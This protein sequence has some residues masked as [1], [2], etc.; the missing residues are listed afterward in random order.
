MALQIVPAVRKPAFVKM[1]LAGVQYSGK[2]YTAL[3]LAQSLAGDKPVIALDFECHDGVNPSTTFY[4]EKFRFS[5]I[6]LIND[7]S[8]QAAL[9]ALKLALSSAPGAIVIDGLASLWH[10]LN[11][12]AEKTAKK[13][14][15]HAARKNIIPVLNE[16]IHLIMTSETHVIATCVLRQKTARSRGANG[17]TIITSL[18]DVLD[19]QDRIELKFPFFGVMYINKDGKNTL[20]LQH[21]KIARFAGQVITQPGRK[22]AAEL[23]EWSAAGVLP[24]TA[25][26]EETPAPPAAESAE[27]GN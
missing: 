16:I 25:P 5:L 3:A 14:D 19:F 6:S 24:Q 27:D 23:H 21:S 13:G 10:G 18:G 17:E 4:A 1:L 12:L 2:T 15:T 9:D 7:H 8:P 11:T 20:A 22:F 26:D